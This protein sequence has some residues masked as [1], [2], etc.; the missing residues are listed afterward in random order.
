M[1]RSP[2]PAELRFHV[3]LIYAEVN[4]SVSGL[5]ACMVGREETQC[6]ARTLVQELH[7]QVSQCTLALMNQPLS[8]I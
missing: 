4:I 6:Y 2:M 8:W 5:D 1:W 3:E 7:E